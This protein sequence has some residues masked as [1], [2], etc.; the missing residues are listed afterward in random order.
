[1]GEKILLVFHFVGSVAIAWLNM[2]TKIYDRHV[3]PHCCSF[4]DFPFE[5]WAS[6]KSKGCIKVMCGE[7]FLPVMVFSENVISPNNVSSIWC[8]ILFLS[9][10]LARNACD[11]CKIGI[12]VLKSLETHRGSAYKESVISLTL[13]ESQIQ[14]RRITKTASKNKTKSSKNT[15][16][17]LTTWYY[18]S[19]QK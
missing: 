1:M 12:A 8:S 4:D 5:D 15:L 6:K 7:H 9:D 16:L 17:T 11:L 19:N 18:R 3:S 2:N 13:S 10:E 14:T